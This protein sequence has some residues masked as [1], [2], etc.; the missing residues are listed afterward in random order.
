M[1]ITRVRNRW[2]AVKKGETGAEAVEFALVAPIL[3]F[4]VFG[5]IYMLL[6]FAAQISL[7]YVTNVGVRYAA[8]PTGAGTY[9]SDTAVR[10]KAV[11]Q[12]PFFSKSSCTPALTGGAVNERMVLTMSCNFPNPAGGAAN[13][14]RQAMFGGGDEIPSTIELSATA[15][16]RKE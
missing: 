6:I 8:I 13:A 15:Q 1:R 14:I 16:S 10:D 9:P 11:A 12:T 5:L 4:L 2:L 7:G 3:L